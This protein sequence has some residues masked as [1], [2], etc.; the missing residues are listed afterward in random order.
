AAWI[1]QERGDVRRC[2][3]LAPFLAPAG[4]PERVS[5]PLGRALSRSPNF[6]VWW[7]AQYKEANPGPPHSY[8]RFPTRVIGE[9]MVLGADVLAR[10]LAAAPACPEIAIVC[11]EADTA[12]DLGAVRELGASWRRSGAKLAE[13]WFPASEKIPHDFIDP[14]QPDARTAAVYP[15]LVRLLTS[16]TWPPQP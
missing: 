3:V 13:L 6:F 14:K 16:E 11:S 4:V 10:A 9:F 8:P 7:N 12:I 15:E 1:A 5:L 2:L